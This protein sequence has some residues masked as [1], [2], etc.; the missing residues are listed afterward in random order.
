MTRI[1]RNKDE[2]VK[3]GFRHVVTSQ[4]EAFTVCGD[5]MEHVWATNNVLLSIIPDI[6]EAL[7][8]ELCSAI[9]D[10][11]ALATEIEICAS[12]EVLPH[13]FIRVLQARSSK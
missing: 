10:T 7:E 1:T 4:D 8:C 12:E 9:N 3:D 6:S 13:R 5:C 2:V 11:L